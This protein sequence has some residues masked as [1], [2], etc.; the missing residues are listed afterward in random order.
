VFS[1]ASIG[2]DPSRGRFESRPLSL[3]LPQDQINRPATTD[4]LP[5]LAEMGQDVG[6]VA[7]GLFQCVSKDSKPGGFKRPGGQDGDVVGGLGKSDDGRRLPSG[8]Q[9]DGAEGVAEDSSQQVGL[10]GKRSQ[11]GW[12]IPILAFGDRMSEATRN[13]TEITLPQ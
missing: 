7:A 6:V 1:L 13:D 4:M 2:A 12:D 9:G 11:D 8:V 5:R 3:L 10:Y